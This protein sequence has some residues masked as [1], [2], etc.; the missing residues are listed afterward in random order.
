MKSE[1]INQLTHSTRDEVFGLPLC[2]DIA[3]SDYRGDY[4]QETEYRQTKLLRKVSFLKAFLRENERI[5]LVTTACSPASLLEQLLTD[6]FFIY[7]K[8]SLLVFTDKRI[9]HIPTKLNYSYR[10]SIAQILYSDCKLIQLKGRKLIVE[11]GNG[12]KETFSYIARKEKR[13]IES[14]LQTIDL[15]GSPG[16]SQKRTYLCPRC[17]SELEEGKYIC[18]NC[19]LEFKSKEKAKKISI[20]YPGGGYFYTGHFILGI[21][22]AIV[23]IMLLFSFIIALVHVMH[24]IDSGEDDMRMFAVILAVEKV[25]T[26]YHSNHYIEEFIPKEKEVAP[27]P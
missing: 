23:E 24:G 10:N 27:M 11:Y 16:R 12:Q 4:R 5:F 14:L 19:N 7:K 25:I 1:S 26:V 17:K 21:E 9:F 6:Y 22:S 18:R 15:G 2:L 8:R 20:I 3:F 13:K